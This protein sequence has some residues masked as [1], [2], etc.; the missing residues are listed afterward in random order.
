MSKAALIFG[1]WNVILWLIQSWVTCGSSVFDE[2]FLDPVRQLPARRR[3]G[4]AGADAERMAA[5][6]DDL[7]GQG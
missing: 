2:D 1:S 7:V 4:A 6:G 3:A 5:V